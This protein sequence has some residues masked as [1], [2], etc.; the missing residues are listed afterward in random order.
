MES[1]NRVIT[2]N[3]PCT[4]CAS[5]LFPSIPAG[6]RGGDSHCG[7]ACLQNWICVKPS[8]TGNAHFSQGPQLPSIIK[9]VLM[10]RSHEIFT[11][12]LSITVN[13]PCHLWLHI[14]HFRPPPAL[15]LVSLA[16]CL[17]LSFPCWLSSGI[18]DKDLSGC[19][20]NAM[21]TVMEFI[22]HGDLMNRGDWTQGTSRLV[23]IC[24][25]PEST[26]CCPTC[27]HRCGTHT[28]TIHIVPQSSN[29]SLSQSLEWSWFNCPNT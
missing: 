25:R 17:A 19:H 27:K 16:L 7:F 11:L 23:A 3:K 15:I 6:E 20:D 5:Q 22:W 29:L 14:F 24:R 28:G 26:P 1:Q 10:V 13:S 12:I 8:I 2:M 21:T 4:C 18:S 9:N